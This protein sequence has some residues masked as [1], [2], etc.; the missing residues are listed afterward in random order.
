MEGDTRITLL[1]RLRLSPDDAAAW[2]EFVELYGRAIYGWCRNWG[3][4]QT[5]AE[6]VTQDV[7]VNLA[8]RMRNFSYDPNQSF[9]AW[10]KTVVHNQVI[11]YL[12]RHRRAV[13]GR[14]GESACE[15]L[16]AV[17]ARDDLARRLHETF[18]QELLQIATARVQLRVD[19][20]TWEAFHL[21]ANEGRSGAEVAKHLGMEVGTV[22]V[23]R[24]R[25]QR[26]LKDEVAR[27]ES[28]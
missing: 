9:R 7:F 28:E 18:D 26:M 14:G 25:V 17:E 27:L 23:A 19:S 8:V 22:F 1:G 20:K 2:S 24:S 13:Q 3:L 5:D 15:L 21:L 4:Q 12:T 11:N 10:L 16:A 6:D